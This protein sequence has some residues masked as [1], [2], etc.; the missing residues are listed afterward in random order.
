[1]KYLAYGF[2]P[3][4]PRHKLC[5]SEEPNEAKQA[6]PRRDSRQRLRWKDG[7]CAKQ[8]LGKGERS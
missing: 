5:P 3:G 1:M 8:S 7:S 6:Y 2:L 4:G